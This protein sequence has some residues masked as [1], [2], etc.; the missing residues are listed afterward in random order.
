MGAVADDLKRRIEAATPGDTVRGLVFNATF[1]LVAELAGAAAARAIDPAGQAHRRE[2]YSYPFADYLRVVQAALAVLEPRLGPPER[3]LWELGSRCATR[4]FA[5]PL[6][7]VMSAIGGGD[8]R[9]AISSAPVAYRSLARSGSP[10]V[11]WVGERHARVVFDRDL[12]LPSFH[13]GALT[14]GL[15][16]LAGVHAQAEVREEGILG[17]VVDLRW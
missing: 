6:G 15:L 1:A 10:T 16:D 8:P 3:V 12:L 14:R 17:A 2:Y 5:S 13:G 4:W 11:E 9:R 7:R